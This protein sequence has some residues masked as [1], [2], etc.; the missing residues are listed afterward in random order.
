MWFANVQ[1]HSRNGFS[2]FLCPASVCFS[3]H[4]RRCLG[5]CRHC[6]MH[7]H[8]KAIVTSTRRHVDTSTRRHV[9]TSTQESWPERKTQESWP[10]GQI[11]RGSTLLI[12][13]AELDDDDHEMIREGLQAGGVRSGRCERVVR[14]RLR[15]AIGTWLSRGA[16]GASATELQPPPHL[17]TTLP[18]PAGGGPRQ[19][20]RR[21]SPRAARPTAFSTVLPPRASRDDLQDGGLGTDSVS[22]PSSIAAWR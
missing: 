12:I 8:N 20:V 11:S 7:H 19:R 3:V 15:T 2:N 21:P 18:A 4:H 6:R 17:L 1:F 16:D 22:R 5:S 9:D 10:N 13:W 14:S